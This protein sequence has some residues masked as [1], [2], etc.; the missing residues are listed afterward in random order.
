MILLWY[1]VRVEG[2]TAPPQAVVLRSRHIMRLIF[3]A[4]ANR[5]LMLRLHDSSP[6]HGRLPCRVRVCLN[7]EQQ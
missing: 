7:M 2:T 5:C 1:H 3:L 6:C 4:T